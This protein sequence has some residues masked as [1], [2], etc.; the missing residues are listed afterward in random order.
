MFAKYY[1]AEYN[2]D[3]YVYRLKPDDKQ[4]EMTLFKNEEQVEQR[5]GFTGEFRLGNENAR[6]WVKH[7]LL[8]SKH[9][10]RIDNMLIELKKIRLGP[11]R[12][13]LTLK[14]IYN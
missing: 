12:K 11:L 2:G 4:N 14:G 10:F 9:E 6:L 5:F 1:Y 13:L 3:I 8:S 7:T